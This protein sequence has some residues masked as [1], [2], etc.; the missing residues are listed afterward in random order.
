MCIRDS[1]YISM[2]IRD[3]EGNYIIKN[4]MFKGK[5]N[6]FVEADEEEKE[7]FINEFQTKSSIPWL[8]LIHI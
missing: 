1:I 2:H 7:G 3:N 6:S 8:S 4:Y 5:Y